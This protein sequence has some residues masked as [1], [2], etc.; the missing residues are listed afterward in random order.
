MRFRTLEELVA[1]GLLESKPADPGRVGRWLER[2]R[3]DHALAADVLARLDRDRAMAVAY[4]AGYRACAG[5]LMLAGYRV[6][7]QP[8]HHRAAIEGAGALLGRRL[9]RSFAGSTRP[10]ASGTRPSTATPRRRP[11]ASCASSSRTWEP[12]ST[13]LRV[14][15]PRRGRSR[16][17]GRADGP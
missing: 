12:C 10:G 17:V 9:G 15:W 8:S 1:L 14:R 16:D 6:T 7:S 2:S 4:E 3:T 11:R 5:L 13:G